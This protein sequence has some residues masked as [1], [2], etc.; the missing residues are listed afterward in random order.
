MGRLANCPSLFSGL[1]ILVVQTLT[2]VM[3]GHHALPLGYKILVGK[4]LYQESCLCSAVQKLRVY[5]LT[6]NGEE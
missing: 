6:C 1:S 4:I 2:L 5:T 3:I